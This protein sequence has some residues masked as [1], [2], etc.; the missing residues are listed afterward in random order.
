MRFLECVQILRL[1]HHGFYGDGGALYLLTPRDDS[2]YEGLEI[3]ERGQECLLKPPR[4]APE[5][6]QRAGCGE[7]RHISKDERNH[8]GPVASGLKRDANPA[9]ADATGSPLS[10]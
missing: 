10:V 3:P 8:S 9:L 6:L 5:A 7:E 4:N 2:C 1:K